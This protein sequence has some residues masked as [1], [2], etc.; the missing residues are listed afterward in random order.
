MFNLFRI[1]E[2]LPL[3]KKPS[4][5]GEQELRFRRTYTGIEV[6]FVNGSSHAIE[7][8]ATTRVT[9]KHC[10]GLRAFR[11]ESPEAQLVLVSFD[12]NDRSTEDGI[13]LLHWRSFARELWSGALIPR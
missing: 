7:V 4:T 8:K 5:L 11:D 3:A 1:A 12:E 10:K 2:Y 9:D 6:D 13:R